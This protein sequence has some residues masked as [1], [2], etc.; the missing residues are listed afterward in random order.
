MSGLIQTKNRA[1]LKVRFFVFRKDKLGHSVPMKNWMRD[2]PELIGL[3]DEILT[4]ENLKKRGFFKPEFVRKMIDDHKAKKVN[5]SHRIWAL[6]VL[7]LWLQ[8]HF[9]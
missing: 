2:S 7:E 6:M 3:V 8:K 4:E 9:D 5:H 1:T